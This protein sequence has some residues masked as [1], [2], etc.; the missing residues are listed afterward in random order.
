MPDCQHLGQVV[1]ISNF[2]NHLEKQHKFIIIE[3]EGLITE[4]RYINHFR[5]GLAPDFSFQRSGD[6]MRPVILKNKIWNFAY[7]II[8]TLI[9]P[10][11]TL[12]FNA[13]YIEGKKQYSLSQDKVRYEIEYTFRKNPWEA[14]VSKLE[15]NKILQ[16]PRK[17]RANHSFLN[18]RF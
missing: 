2:V 9:P 16:Y 17:F 1:D 3:Y 5:V 10:G 11:D 4:S 6:C 12:S 18:L 13:I 7:A 15:I 14:N 8:P